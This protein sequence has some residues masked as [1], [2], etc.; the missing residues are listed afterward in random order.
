[1]S[2][3]SKLLLMRISFALSEVMSVWQ[4]VN[5]PR[6]AY[7]PYGSMLRVGAAGNKKTPIPWSFKKATN[8][9]EP[10]IRELQSHAL[11][12]G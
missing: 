11:P 8:G 1:M 7:L 5:M 3:E 2:G 12:L 9:F 4:T 6:G 10:M